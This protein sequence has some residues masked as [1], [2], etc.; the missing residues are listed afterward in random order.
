MNPQIGPF[1]LEKPSLA[2]LILVFIGN[3]VGASKIKDTEI[4]CV[5]SEVAEIALT[6]WASDINP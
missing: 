4:S 1:Q 3:R 5:F 2:L 6:T